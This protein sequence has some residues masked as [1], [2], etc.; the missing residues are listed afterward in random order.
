MYL[1]RFTT[2]GGGMIRLKLFNERGD[3]VHKLDSIDFRISA[4]VI[5]N[6]E[7]RGPIAYSSGGSWTYVGNYYPKLCVEGRCRLL[8]GIPR[9]PSALS[10]PIGVFSITDSLLRAN[11]VAFAQY[12]EE[13]EMWQGLMRPIWWQVM[14]IFSDGTLTLPMKE[15]RIPTLNPWTATVSSAEAAFAPRD[16]AAFK[17]P[18]K[19]A[20][21]ARRAPG[22]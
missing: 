19:S 3:L 20:A 17:Q 5:W 10:E 15:L 2:Y 18:G 13:S 22:V 21:A 9:A 1:P 11:G 12:V 4:G 16:I 6:P 8:F 7:L 14:R